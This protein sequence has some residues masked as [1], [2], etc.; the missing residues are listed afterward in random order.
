MLRY[1]GKETNLRQGLDRAN[2]ATSLGGVAAAPLHQTRRTP[3]ST[4]RGPL[5]GGSDRRR[6][7]RSG[8]VAI[9][10]G[11]DQRKAAQVDALP[12]QASQLFLRHRR[13]VQERPPHQGHLILATGLRAS[14]NAP[15]EY[16]RVRESYAPPNNE[17]GSRVR[18]QPIINLSTA[19]LHQVEVP[20]SPENG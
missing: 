16:E 8:G 10:T 19:S 20:P 12:C 3:G 7:P 17:S 5:L 13:R 4:L 1:M 9:H 6:P 15:C 2:P 11:N 14:T 18:A